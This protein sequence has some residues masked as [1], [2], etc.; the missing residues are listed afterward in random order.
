MKG[1]YQ[2]HILKEH[3]LCPYLQEYKSQVSPEC[4]CEISAQKTQQIIS[5]RNC[6]FWAEARTCCFCACIFKC[7]WAAAPALFSRIGLC[8]NRSYLRYSAKTKQQ[9][10]FDYHV[11]CT[12]IMRFLNP[13]PFKLLIYGFLSAHVW[14]THAH[15]KLLSHTQ[16]C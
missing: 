16:V 5:F 4:V 3:I 10:S 11:Y 14:S 15:R 8:L 9:L 12:E 7:K 13:Y 2:G 6:L 1:V